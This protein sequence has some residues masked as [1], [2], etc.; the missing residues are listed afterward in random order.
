MLNVLRFLATTVRFDLDAAMQEWNG[1]D[2]IQ[3]QSARPGAVELIIEGLV[4]ANSSENAPDRYL[5]RLTR[6]GT[7]ISRYEEFTFKRRG[8]R[9]RRITVKWLSSDHRGRR[10]GDLLPQAGEQ[11]DNRARDP[12]EVVRQRGWAGDPEF[13]RVPI[14]ILVFEPDVSAARQ[15]AR[16]YGATIA[17][18]VSNLADAL[19]R[20]RMRDPDSWEVLTQELARC[21]PGLRS[22]QLVPVGGAAKAVSVQLDERGVAAPID[23]A[24]ASYGTV[25]LLALLAALHEPDPPPFMA[26]EEIDH[27]LHPYAMDV[28]LDRLRAA[29]RRTQILVAT[30]SPTLV[31]RLH[32]EEIIVFDRNPKTGAS[33]IPAAS[34]DEIARAVQASDWGPGELW[35]SGVIRGVP[36]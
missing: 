1:F 7:S 35:F 11:P 2:H 29:S 27:G 31:N 18:D 5:L 28:L 6:H 25:R 23:L 34:A 36:A 19:H 24:D 32:Q 13:H 30:H 17:P 8:G 10:A 4:T 33:L 12:A 15:A 20:I 21:L 26:I 3:R 16:E 9:G 14:R 22:V